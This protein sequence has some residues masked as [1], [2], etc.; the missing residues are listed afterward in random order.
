MVAPVYDATEAAS[1]SVAIG[2]Q[3]VA[4]GFVFRQFSRI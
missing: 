3:G 1:P 2:V 4:G